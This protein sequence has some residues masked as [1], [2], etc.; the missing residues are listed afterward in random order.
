MPNEGE[1]NKGLDSR[2]SGRCRV[3]MERK[4]GMG[5]EEERNH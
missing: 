1:I 2:E 3:V 4:K 5:M